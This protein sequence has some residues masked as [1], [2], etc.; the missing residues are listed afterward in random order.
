MTISPARFCPNPACE[1]R[2]HA[3]S[4]GG[5]GVIGYICIH[6]H[7]TAIDWPRAT[8]ILTLINENAKH[9][10]ARRLERRRAKEVA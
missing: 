10:W 4:L 8:H 6:C 2:M 7:H 5:R 9:Q 3:V 1:R